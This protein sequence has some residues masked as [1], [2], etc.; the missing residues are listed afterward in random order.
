VFRL[1][2]GVVV[3][4]KVVDEAGNPVAEAW[5]QAFAEFHGQQ[6]AESALQGYA[7]T[8]GLGDYRIQGLTPGEFLIEASPPGTRLGLNG[9]VYMSEFYRGTADWRQANPIESHEGDVLTGI[10][11]TLSAAQPASLSGQAIDGTTGEPLDG[12]DIFVQPTF[13]AKEDVKVVARANGQTA[14]GLQGRFRVT[15][16][17]PGS[18]V[19]SASAHS[20]RTSLYGQ[21]PVSVS[22]GE[23]FTGLQIELAPELELSGRVSADPS[24]TLKLQDLW[25]ILQPDSSSVLREPASG[26][27][28]PDGR[29]VLQ[30]MPPGKYRVSVSG[31]P[32]HPWQYYLKSATL[33]GADVLENGLT[34]AA[35]K[36]VGTLRL[37]L[38]LDGGSIQ[39]AVLNEGGKP[40]AGSAVVLIPDPPRRSL[41]DLYSTTRTD[42]NGLF[43]LQALAPGN[44]K[45][46]AWK[47]LEQHSFEDPDFIHRFEDRG[48]RV[49]INAR[50]QKQVQLQVI[51][52]SAMPAQ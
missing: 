21:L 18:Y 19:L 24:P 7:R 2:P 36:P 29:F 32:W 14:K 44:Y 45:L 38:S 43:S 1:E 52:A 25:V 35:G 9:R 23:A 4:G 16:L 49:E 20:G 40:V 12:A 13:E 48:K 39:G 15:L 28:A 3:T 50:E 22:P 41:T 10:D 31:F 8:D 46:F 30:D 34:L 17:P 42:S 51:P 11:I 33:D 47:D 37:F 27:A 5:V 26:K 6:G